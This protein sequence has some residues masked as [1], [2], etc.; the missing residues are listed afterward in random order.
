MHIIAA[1]AEC[2]YEALQPEF[3]TYQEQVLKNIKALAKVL[4]DN[5]LRIISGGTDNHLILVDV[6]S[7]GVNGKEAEA[8][9]DEVNITVNKN[10][11]PFD[12]ESPFKTSGIRLGSPAMTTRGLKEVDFE[13]IGHIIIDALHNKDKEQLKLRVKKITDKYPL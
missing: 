6:T 9:L 2:F 13:E 4:S 7:L 8:I 5:G 1:K 11:I 10:T 12:Q 3:K